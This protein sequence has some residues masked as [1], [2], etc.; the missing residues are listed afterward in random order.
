MPPGRSNAEVTK[1][2]AGK[3]DVAHEADERS[4]QRLAALRR[5]QAV[6]RHSHQLGGAQVALRR[7]RVGEAEGGGR[8]EDHRHAVGHQ[9]VPRPVAGGDVVT[10]QPR[11]RVGGRVRDVHTRI[12]EADA[13]NRL[14][15]EL[16]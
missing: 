13:G 8:G 15:V 7:G 5:A 9:R 2:P 11:D 3:T 6:H 12:A 1:K 10:H 16:A 4:G 14:A